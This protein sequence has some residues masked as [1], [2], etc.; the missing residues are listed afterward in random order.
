MATQP[1]EKLADL[2][3]IVTEAQ[4][5]AKA[6]YERSSDAAG[7]LGD[8]IKGNAG[9][10]VDSGKALGQGLKE[11]GEGNLADSRHAL[12]IFGSDLQELAGVKS[13]DDLLAL[14]GKLARRN[15]DAALAYAARN[16]RALGQVAMQTLAPLSSRAKA[17]LRAVRR[18]A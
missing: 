8:L 9:A 7:K 10:V 13:S 16:S 14:Q 1:K 12:R 15:L 5:N 17:N 2:R 3:A 6:A 11:I 18:G 4:A